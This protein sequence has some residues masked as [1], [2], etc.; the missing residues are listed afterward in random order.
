MMTQKSGSMFAFSTSPI[1]P[2][3]FTQFTK[4]VLSFPEKK[5]VVSLVRSWN[6]LTAFV[7]FILL[8]FAEIK[9]CLE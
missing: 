8:L 7:I 1:G 6:L 2:A 4:L 5:T 3:K 9:P